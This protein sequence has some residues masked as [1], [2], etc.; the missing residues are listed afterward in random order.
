[1]ANEG[2]WERRRAVIARGFEALNERDH[3]AFR[4][5][6]PAGMEFHSVAGAME[7]RAVMIGPEEF[8][9]FYESM[10]STW[11]ELRWEIT[12]VREAGE[13]TA[14]AYRITG[15]AR[16]SGIPLEQDLGQVWTWR[17]GEA[18]PA[19]VQVYMDPREAFAAVAGD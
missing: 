16:R 8:L 17:E 1:M 19:R 14:I 3:D 13:R 10:R 15:V 6:I 5:L 7:G 11:D 9:G 18:V 12:E 2:L 4:E